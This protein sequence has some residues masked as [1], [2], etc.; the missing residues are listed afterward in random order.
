MAVFSP[1]EGISTTDESNLQGYGYQ[2]QER[3]FGRGGPAGNDFNQGTWFAQSCG[4]RSLQAEIPVGG[5]V[6]VVCG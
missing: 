3:A 4:T 5:A 1:R 6:A 2:S